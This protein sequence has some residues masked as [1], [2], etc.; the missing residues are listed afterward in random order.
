MTIAIVP[1]G[2]IGED[3]LDFLKN[4]LQILLGR[5][6]QI[7]REERIPEFAFN[8]KRNQYFS[9]LILRSIMENMDYM[10]YERVLAVV[11]QDLY[12]PWLNFVFGEAGERVAIIST[13]RLSR[14]FYGL[15][16]DRKI[17]LKRL[18][19]EAVHELGHTYGLIHC[20]NANCVMFFSNSIIDTDRKGY[21]FCSS[22]REKISHEIR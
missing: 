21:K 7:E 20:R 12:V 9:T 1:M 16:P 13:F 4:N 15:E 10:G 17:F 3:T 8:M 19:T 2:Y 14:E 5:E 18:L 11:D 22:C 6:I